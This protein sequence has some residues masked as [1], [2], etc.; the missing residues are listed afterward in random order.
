MKLITYIFNSIKSFL[1]LFKKKSKPQL[2]DI[3]FDE[4]L[5]REAIGLEC[6]TPKIEIPPAENK[7]EAVCFIRQ[8]LGL[9][10]EDQYTIEDEN[11]CEFER[12]DSRYYLEGEKIMVGQRCRG[13]EKPT[14]FTEKD[15]Y[16]DIASEG[17]ITEEELKNII[18]ADIFNGRVYY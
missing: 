16:E 5:L 1:N 12:N 17:T 18:T 10:C 3:T 11:V 4:C 9:D 7:A 13:Y 8:G 2:E 15:I 6:N 14:E